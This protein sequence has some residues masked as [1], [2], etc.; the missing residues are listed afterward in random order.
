[1]PTRWVGGWVGGWRVRGL[2]CVNG[3]GVGGVR[4]VGHGCGDVARR[5]PSSDYSFCVFPFL[6]CHFV[7]LLDALPS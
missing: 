2:E 7:L 1:M 3:V 5:A 4:T 6:L